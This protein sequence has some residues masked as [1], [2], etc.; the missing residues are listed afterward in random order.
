MA[1]KPLKLA[2]STNQLINL[3]QRYKLKTAEVGAKHQSINLCQ[4][5]HDIAV[6]LLTLALS[7]NQSIN[8]LPLYSC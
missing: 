8:L 2:L 1:V 5:Y 3:C 7:T 4:Y 6:Q